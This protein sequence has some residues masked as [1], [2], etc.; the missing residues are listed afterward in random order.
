MSAN[1]PKVCE[2]GGGRYKAPIEYQGTLSDDG[3]EIEG[4][5]RIANR[6]WGKFMMIREGRRIAALTRKK[7]EIA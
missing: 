3:T 1:D 6:T 2:N 7:A 5:W 4:R